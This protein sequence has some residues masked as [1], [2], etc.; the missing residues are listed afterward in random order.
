MGGTWC[1]TKVPGVDVEPA[2]VTEGLNAGGASQARLG[3]WLSVENESPHQGV[4]PTPRG[5]SIY[6][7]WLGS[8]AMLPGGEKL[9]WVWSEHRLKAS[10]PSR[11]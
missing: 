4:D 1:R 2:P 8:R 6:L 5:R 7:G 10:L 3:G 11:P 9:T